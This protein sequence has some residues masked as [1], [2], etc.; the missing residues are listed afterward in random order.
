MQMIKLRAVL[1]LVLAVDTN[2]LLANGSSVRAHVFVLD[3]I[4]GTQ[5]R[6][7]MN[8]SIR[9]TMAVHPNWHAFCIQ[10]LHHSTGSMKCSTPI[11]R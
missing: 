3:G 7:G 9:C 10:L 2:L 11:P 5:G 4:L 1:C 6:I 8:T